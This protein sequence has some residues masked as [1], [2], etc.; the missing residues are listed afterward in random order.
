MSQISR[1]HGIILAFKA[2]ASNL[3]REVPK[4]VISVALGFAKKTAVAVPVSVT[5]TTLFLST[6]CVIY[7]FFSLIHYI[8]TLSM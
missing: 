4:A 6:V 2:P 1:L 7:S 3:S 5:I 8:S